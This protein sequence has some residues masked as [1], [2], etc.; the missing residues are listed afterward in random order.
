MLLWRQENNVDEVAQK[1]TELGDFNRLKHFTLISQF[2]PQQLLYTHTLAGSPVSIEAWGSIQ[3]KE[4][5][6]NV[7]PQ[8]WFEFALYKQEYLRLVL[9]GR[10]IRR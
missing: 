8:Q 9:E 5:L 1:I 4:L 7:D 10:I 3:T 6:S 2:C